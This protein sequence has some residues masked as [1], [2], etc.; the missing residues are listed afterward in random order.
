MVVEKR[1]HFER[2]SQLRVTNNGWNP[3]TK[4]DLS[5]GTFIDSEESEWIEDVIFNVDTCNSKVVLYIIM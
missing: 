3:S 4:M 1:H 2:K 5:D